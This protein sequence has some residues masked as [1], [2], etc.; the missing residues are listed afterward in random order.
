MLSGDV[1]R[2]I[3]S[4]PMVLAC[5]LVASRIV[6]MTFVPLLAFYLL[7]P[8]A[9]PEAAG[10]R[11]SGAAGRYAQAVRW[12]L[13][14]RFKAMA[15]SALVVG[16]GLL[17]GTSIKTDFF[18]KDLS[19]LSYLD[20]WLPTDAPLT[21]TNQAAQQAE[22]VVRSVAE[23]YGVDHP[24]P[25]GKPRPILASLTSYVGGGAPRFWFSVAPE[26]QQLNYA[27]VLIQVVDKHDTG[28]LLPL[29]QREL[30]GGVAGAL[31]DVRELEM[32]KPVGIPVSIRISGSDLPTLR[33]LAEDAKAILRDVPIARGIRDDWGQET[34][35]VKL[36]VD[37]V[38]ANDAGISNLDV[39]VASASAMNGAPLTTLREDDQQIPV[40]LRLRMEDR[41]QLSDVQSLIVTSVSGPGRAML[42]QVSDIEQATETEKLRRR[43]QFRTVSVGAFPVPGALPSE[44]MNA[45]R[46]ALTRF[47]ASLPP[48]YKMVIGGSEEEQNKGFVEM[49]IVM[50]TSVGLIFL[51]LVLQFNH[52]FKPLIVFATIPFGV[53]G[54]LVALAIMGRPFGFIAFLGVASLI[55]VI[56]SHVIVLF[57]FIEEAREQGAHLE[58][59][60]IDAG[61]QRLRPVLVTVGAT[62]IALFPLALH[63]GPFWEPLCYA[64]IGGLLF[65][66][67][68]T[69][70][71]VPLL[72]YMA[73]RD[74]KLVKWDAA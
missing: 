8:D 3:H 39:A 26:V 32:G 48:G 71:L 63:G 70:W 68:G 20:V 38:R 60:L 6:S 25:D 36:K 10:E 73:V 33:R 44:V 23:K 61:I 41:S 30:S 57:D 43:D 55:G 12:A 7:K 52:A 62:V 11:R 65:A 54:A 45:A 46:P 50:M 59:A 22:A 29:L 53:V 66:T 28:H 69:L 9:K 37:Q 42:R 47:A 58:D 27:Q 5:S 2:F 16:V 34:F 1:G 64:Q 18:P 19:Y 13:G 51:A 4:I 74:L 40:V 72:Y 15:V 14:H 35:T 56:V 49:A 24:G 17:A 31:V 21:A 67:V